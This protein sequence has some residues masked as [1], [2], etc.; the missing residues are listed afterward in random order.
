MNGRIQTNAL[1]P[2]IFVTRHLEGR[3]TSETTGKHI[4]QIFCFSKNLLT[5]SN[6]ITPLQNVEL[7]VHAKATLVWRM[8]TL[9]IA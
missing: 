4:F 5:A 7:S 8:C 1:T 6:Y 2:V 9:Y 3:I